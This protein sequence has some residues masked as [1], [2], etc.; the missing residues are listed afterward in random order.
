MS[1]TSKIVLRHQTTRW[2]RF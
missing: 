2:T 1:P